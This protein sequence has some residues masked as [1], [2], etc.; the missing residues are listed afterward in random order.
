[1]RT[2][3][4]PLISLISLLEAIDRNHNFTITID[5]LK[6]FKALLKKMTNEWAVCLAKHDAEKRY[7]KPRESEV[8]AAM[9]AQLLAEEASEQM[10]MRVSFPDRTYTLEIN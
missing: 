7:T 8:K 6:G 4:D 10:V 9:H 3:P 1:M 5:T 2:S